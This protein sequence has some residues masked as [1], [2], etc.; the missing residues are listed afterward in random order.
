[1]E[2]FSI[3]FVCRAPGTYALTVKI[4]FS[5]QSR[6]GTIDLRPE[7]ELVCPKAYT[8]YSVPYL[9]D[10]GPSYVSVRRYAWNNDHYEEA[11]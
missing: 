4:P 8:Q 1:M 10:D 7:A 2:V 5:Y 3:P 6:E 9:E 11:P